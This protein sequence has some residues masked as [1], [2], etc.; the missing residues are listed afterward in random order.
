M[1]EPSTIAYPELERVTDLRELD[2]LFPHSLEDL[3]GDFLIERSEG[4]SVP[5]RIA[6]AD[7]NYDRIF[8]KTD[9][10]RRRVRGIVAFMICQD[11]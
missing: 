11:A 1:L 10:H 4:R 3:Q 9:L 6:V 5:R 7:G 8:A 2:P